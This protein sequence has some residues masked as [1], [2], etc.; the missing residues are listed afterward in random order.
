MI[1]V[2]NAILP[3][4]LL[5]LSGQ[6]LRHVP[7]FTADFWR[8]MDTLGYYVLYPALL[9]V[10]IMRADFS[11]LTLDSVAIALGG[12]NLVSV[13]GV[14]L[15]WPL[16][17]AT[18]KISRP[19][20]SSVFQAT[21]RWNGFM[22]FAVAER[23]FPP[24]GAAMV[25][26][27]MAFLIIPVNIEAVAVVSWFA[28]KDPNFGAVLRKIAINPMVLAT[29]SALVVRALPF[30]L[31]EPLMQMLD[32]VAR[33]ALGMGLLSI[34][35]GLKPRNVLRPNAALVLATA[36]KLILYPALVL[37]LALALGLQGDQISYL[38]L[39]AAVPTAMNGYVLARQMG[40]D[41]E[42]Y[43]A[44][45][46]VQTAAAFLTIPAVLAIANQLSG[47]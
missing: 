21:V 44:I 30:T 46:T 7:L 15:A 22:A 29:G 14:L 6:G 4:F 2:F 31:P 5:I 26:L 1:P 8:G 13:A 11:A 28:G 16:L 3:I 24:E 34:G 9:F 45:V 32:L 12:A 40:G 23:L 43:A 33:A 18:S 19:G 36:A 42:L 41:A 20:F 27:V 35:A 25:A 39:C 10:T 47:G 37:A 17:R 38:A